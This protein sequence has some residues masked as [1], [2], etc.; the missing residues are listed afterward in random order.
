M[1]NERALGISFIYAAQSWRQ[2]ASIFG[3]TDARALFG[4]TNVLIMFGGS[5]DVA[6]NREVSDLVGTTRVTR[7][8]WQ[9]GQAGGRSTHGDDMLIL[10]P[11]EVRQLPEKH[12]L[13]VAENSKPII[14]RLTRC[15]DGKRGQVLRAQQREVR[16][17]LQVRRDQTVSA[18]ARAVAALASGRGDH[19]L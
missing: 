8:T 14:A 3:E 10:R 1:A 5:K 2:L 16:K 7:T 17:Q 4:L 6:F 13:V 9:L 18:D 19:Q 15:I 12:A 11:E